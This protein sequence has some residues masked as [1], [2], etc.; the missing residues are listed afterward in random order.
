VYFSWPCGIIDL[1]HDCADVT[2]EKTQV[3]IMGNINEPYMAS[4][5]FEVAFTSTP[6]RF[7][8]ELTIVGAYLLLI[9][10]YRS[11]SRTDGLIRS[12]RS[13]FDEIRTAADFRYVTDL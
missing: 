2:G 6:P 7:L 10:L 12:V 8:L 13:T 1:T 3:N 4:N 11:C 9:Y 5:R